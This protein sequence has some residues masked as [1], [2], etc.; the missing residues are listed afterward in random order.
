LWEICPADF[1]DS[2]AADKLI[3]EKAK[4]SYDCQI[5]MITGT[6]HYPHVEKPKEVVEAILEF[7]RE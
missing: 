2:A 1:P 5:K 6:G 3:A 7:L 4:G